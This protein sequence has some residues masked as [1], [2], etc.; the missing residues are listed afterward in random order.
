MLY[1]F[2]LLNQNVGGTV[3]IFIILEDRQKMFSH[4]IQMVST[5]AFQ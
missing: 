4:I 3:R 1:V 5:R 2:G